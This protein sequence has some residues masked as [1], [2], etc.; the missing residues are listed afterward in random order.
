MTLKEISQRASDHGWLN[1][2]WLRDDALRLCI[3]LFLNWLYSVGLASSRHHIRHIGSECKLDVRMQFSEMPDRSILKHCGFCFRLFGR[4]TLACYSP[5]RSYLHPCFCGV[6][7]VVYILVIHSPGSCGGRSCLFSIIISL[8]SWVLELS[9]YLYEN[10][11]H[12][13]VGEPAMFYWLPKSTARVRDDIQDSMDGVLIC[14]RPETTIKPRKL[15][16][17]VLRGPILVV[18]AFL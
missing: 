12:E 15:D 16:N 18:V 8:L 14:D 10:D 9:A 5:R 11:C 3:Q 4:I 13:S 6:S 1:E 17:P 2:R 7:F